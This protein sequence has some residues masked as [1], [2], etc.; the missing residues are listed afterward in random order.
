MT[1]VLITIGHLERGGAEI[2]ILQAMQEIEK[3]SLALNVSIFV[4]SG[5]RGALSKEF[6]A[7][8]VNLIM[9]LPGL[10][11]LLR[12]YCVLRKT[13]F[14]VLHANASLAGGVYNFVAWLAGVKTR[15]SHIR[16]TGYDEQGI[17]R[18]FKNVAFR[19]LLNAFSTR[20]VGVVDACR[21]FSDT[22]ISRWTTIYNGVI[23]PLNFPD[24]LSRDPMSSCELRVLMLGR[25][26]VP[27]N[28]IRALSIVETLIRNYPSRSVRLD[29][30]GRL[31]A[32]VGA[33]F[34]SAVAQKNLDSFVFC[35]GESDETYSWLR[36]ASVLLLTSKR[37]GLPGV[38]LEASAV[39]TPVV[40]SAL[41]GVQEVAKRLSGVTLCHLDQ[42]DEEWAEA[43]V[44]AGEQADNNRLASEF[45][46][47]PFSFNQHC[48]ALI[49]LW[50]ILEEH[51]KLKKGKCK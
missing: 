2:R 47:S 7:A 28:P 29:V 34:Q 24:K 50:G 11:G 13:R 41:P 30:V 9:G 12:L 1:R 23:P 44:R 21:D 14:D 19:L 4:I 39:G 10:L 45:L 31:D 3:R 18:Q 43:I 25:V 26:A 49:K 22:P 37:E 5:Q 16:S 46:D 27:K 17:V 33:Q 15:I 20:V 40:A 48:D 8:G 35:H 38:I 36:A 32:V 6:E 42:P 51:E